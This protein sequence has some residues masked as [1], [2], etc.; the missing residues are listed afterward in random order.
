MVSFLRKV[1]QAETRA[2]EPDLAAI[3]AKAKGNVRSALNALEL[4]LL[5]AQEPAETPKRTWFDTVSAATPSAKRMKR[6]L[7][8][9]E[10]TGQWDRVMVEVPA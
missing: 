6:I 5:V 9:N 7:V 2:P 8:K 10:S 3:A 1:W 4:K